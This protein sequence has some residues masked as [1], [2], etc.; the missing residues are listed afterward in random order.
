MS[1][2]QSLHKLLDDMKTSMLCAGGI[3]IAAP[4]VGENIRAFVIELESSDAESKLLFEFINPKL[5]L[6]RG[7]IFFEEGCLSF[8]GLMCALKR[9]HSLRVDYQD[10]LGKTRTLTASDLLAVAIQHEYDHLEGVLF[11]DRAPIWKR[12][13]LKRKLKR[14]VTL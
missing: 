10:R 12:W 6:F 2:D 4:Q 9:A 11:I 8:P 1:F 13:W 7:K 14:G 5:S 3:A